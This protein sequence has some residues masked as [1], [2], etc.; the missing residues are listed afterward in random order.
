M[1]VLAVLAAATALWWRSDA[2]ATDSA[3]AQQPLAES[4]A[5]SEVPDR[6]REVWREPS[7]ATPHP[8]VAGP[9][10]VTGAGGD[11][12]GH[13]AES[14]RPAWHY[15]RDLPLCTVD[16]Q[17]DRVIAVHGKTRNCSEVTSLRGDTG[18]R[19][20]QRNSDAE[21]GTRLLS[22]GDALTATGVRSFETW[23]SDLVRTQ[24]YGLP[25]A[26]K[27]PDNNMNRPGCPFE[28]LGSGDE[29]I[30]V[31][32]N[33]PREQGLRLTTIKA[34][35]E[36]EES[37]EEVFSVGIGEAPATVVSVTEDRVAVAFRD[38]GEVLVHDS[39]GAVQDR[40]PVRTGPPDDS[41]NVDLERVQRGSLDYWFTGADVLALDPVTL[42]PAWR[43][44]DVLGPATDFGGRVLVP[45]P[46]GIAVLDPDTG[47]RERVLPVDRQGHDG[48]VSL[49]SAGGVLL[50]Q[51]GDELVALSGS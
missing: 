27:N 15:S 7:P 47:A 29:Q 10:V 1:I 12:T 24:Q 44:P 26:P 23:R 13:D 41:G 50:E 3:P 48:P 35:P 46:D 6:L 33:C 30:A 9:A 38:R 39:S 4:P 18:V 43:A 17:W 11:V 51:R 16:E 22:D 34:E 25:P 42:T 2:R 32:E 20:P 40:Y 28:S 36:D 45:V 49:D 5:P 21:P 31:V 14:G 8:V 37:P 19:A